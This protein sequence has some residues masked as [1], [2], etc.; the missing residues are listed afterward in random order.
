MAQFEYRCEKCGHEQHMYCSFEESLKDHKC[1]ECAEITT[2]VFPRSTTYK[3][4]CLGSSKDYKHR[5]Q[6]QLRRMGKYN[7]PNL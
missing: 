2:R 7:K 3:F 4:N 5:E 1:E 6:Q